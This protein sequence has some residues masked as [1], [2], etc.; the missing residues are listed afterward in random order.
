MHMTRSPE[1]DAATSKRPAAHGGA[2]GSLPVKNDNY[3]PRATSSPNRAKRKSAQPRGS[4]LTGCSQKTE[5]ENTYL[6]KV[7]AKQAVDT[8]FFKRR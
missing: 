5:I 7:I 1:S 8:T 3:A 2:E 4:Q 6:K